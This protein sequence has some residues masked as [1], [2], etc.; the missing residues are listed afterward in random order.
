M[1]IKENPMNT[2]AASILLCALFLA[3]ASSAFAQ[4]RYFCIK[5][6][7]TPICAIDVLAQ[8][9]RDPSA[10]CNAASPQCALVCLAQGGPGAME[11]YGP[12]GLPAIPVT[13]EMLSGLS[14]TSQPESE[15]M[16]QSQYQACI[17]SCRMDPINAGNQTFLGQCYSSCQSVLSGCGKG[18]REIQ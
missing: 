3:A 13:R 15:E 8:T 4:E 6:D 16:C 1:Q 2:K 14:M 5:P 10:L 9:N 7:G 11:K 12:M 18:N 17:E